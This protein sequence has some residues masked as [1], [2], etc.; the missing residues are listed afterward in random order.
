[1]KDYGEVETKQKRVSDMFKFNN[2]MFCNGI[3]GNDNPF[4]NNNI[5]SNSGFFAR[6]TNDEANDSSNN[7]NN[8][9]SINNNVHSFFSSDN[10]DNINDH[11]ES[12]QHNPFLL[13]NASST[14]SFNN[15]YQQQEV[16]ISN[17]NNNNIDYNNCSDKYILSNLS[18][19]DFNASK[20]V[21][22]GNGYITIEKLSNTNYIIYRN[23]AYRILLTC[24]IYPQTT[25]FTPSTQT[26]FTAVIDKLLN[27]TAS[28]HK[29]CSLKLKFQSRSDRTSFQAIFSN[30]TAPINASSPSKE[31]IT[32]ISSIPVYTIYLPQFK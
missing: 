7:N 26:P 32:H 16:S 30:I 9:F 18:E 25:S 10:D 2:D 20:Y 21:S 14:P 23:T 5:S 4:M 6:T 11:K 27:L 12:P 1:M 22:K 17:N 24:I 29:P 3:N 13:T 19:Y 31:V 15:I 8:I 28:P